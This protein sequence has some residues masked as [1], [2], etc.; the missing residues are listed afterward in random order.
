MKRT[1]IRCYDESSSIEIF[2]MDGKV[3]IRIEELEPGGDFLTVSLNP[4]KAKELACF[5]LRRA[6]EME[7]EA[8]PQ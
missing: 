8:E 6:K 1:A 7:E 5:I 3:S 4:D 2:G